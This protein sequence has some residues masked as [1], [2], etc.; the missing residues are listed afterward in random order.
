MPATPPVSP[1]TVTPRTTGL[2]VV[3][4]LAL[5]AVLLVGSVRQE[6]QTFDEPNHLF[7]GFEYWK[8]GDFGRN[9]EHP[10]LVKFLAAIPLLSMGLKEPSP[11]PIPFFK[12]QDAVNGGQLVYSGDADAILLRG[13]LV[14]ALFS[15]ALAIL[16]FFAAREMFSPLAGVLALGLFTLEPMLLANGALVTTD[17]PLTC[18]FFAAVYTFY[19]YVKKSSLLRLALCAAATA[20]CILTKHSGIV[21]FPTLVLLG[22]AEVFLVSP[23]VS[24]DDQTQSQRRRRLLV[25]LAI[26]LIAIVVISYVLLW[27]IYGFRYAARPNQLQIIPTL[28]Q[29]ST[30]LTHPLQRSIIDFLARHRLFPE[31]YLFGWVDILLI[32][33]NRS[34]FV[35]GRV[36]GSGVW[37]YFPAVFI[38]KTSLTLIILLLLVPFA[39]IRDRRREFL[40]LALPIAF[41]ALV[42]I[43]SMLNLGAR[44][45]LPIYPFCI[46]L[47][48][49]AAASFVTRS[50]LGK[51]FVAAL[52]LFTVV[53]SL[54]AFP[55]YL[56][57][58][59]ELVGGPSH[60]YLV[61]ADANS[62][63]G[64][65]LKWT[66][67][68][69]DRH[70]TSDCWFDSYNP[71]S[72]PAY[73]GIQCKP[74]ISGF[75]HL[76]GFAPPTVPRI[77]TGTILI[78]G[79][80]LSGMMW[81]PGDMNPYQS[82]N[83]RKPD[84]MIENIILVYHGTFD[85]PLL[86]AQTNATAATNLLRQHRFPEAVAL[87][88]TAVQQ[89]PDSA[90]V[91]AVLGQC[92]LA[93]GRTAE[94][95]QAIATAI[96]LAQTN[97]PEYQKRLIQ[98]LQQR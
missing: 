90:E 71:F 75:G 20:L 28:S 89:A 68:Y 66:K 6:S 96:H 24:S 35:L 3:I 81:G 65:G 76:V 25:Q 40:F 62:D 21:I 22:L 37:Y 42:A 45:I 78:S 15:L 39:R 69:L 1:S 94:G 54:H 64:Q 82:F 16:V 46:V 49:A 30:F 77:L 86:A 57:Y 26:A 17:M 97:H 2:V 12:A 27:A 88:Q 29:Y 34:T 79:T 85:L 56:A 47:A 10:P 5:F 43:F 33:G 55:D 51:V 18:A 60:D 80:D 4:L 93:S 50:T 13:R 67:T 72:N 31:A 9:P 83:D 63:W 23:E 38:I 70:P 52:L 36:L 53:S 14:V 95:Q 91:N 58:S 92:L 19:R 87:A 59:N 44:H 41:Y 7:A 73:Y 11:V 98:S 61:L 48:G 84:A 32:P 74:L 8:H